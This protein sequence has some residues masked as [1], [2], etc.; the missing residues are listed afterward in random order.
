L[1]STFPFQLSSS[2]FSLN[3]QGSVIGQQ[4]FVHAAMTKL[5]MNGINL[6]EVSAAFVEPIVM[7]KKSI[8][9]C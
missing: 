2:S 1:Q 3:I 5:S 4:G 9:P 7:G 6:P 8:N